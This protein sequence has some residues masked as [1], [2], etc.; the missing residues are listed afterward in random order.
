MG[1]GSIAVIVVTAIMLS[2][3]PPVFAQTVGDVF[4]TVNVSVV[5]IRAKGRD[6]ATEG[7]PVRFSEVG[8]GVL[9]STDGKIMTAAHVVH[10]MT[11]SP[12]SS[13]AANLSGLKSSRPSRR[14]ICP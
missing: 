11:T 14:P 7:G 3:S 9:I 2:V 5:V 13:P 4:R 6:V 8:S 10:A 12:S 1:L